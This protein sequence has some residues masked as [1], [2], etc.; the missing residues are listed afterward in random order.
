MVIANHHALAH[1]YHL[2]SA[3]FAIP[4][5]RCVV[6]D[7]QQQELGIGQAGVLA[8]DCEQSPL[9][10]FQGYAASARQPFVGKY[11]ITGDMVSLNADGGI[12]FIARNDDV[13]TTSGYRIGPFD[14]E[15]TLLECEAVFESAVIGKPDALRTEIIKAF[16]VLKAQYSASEALKQQLQDY[17]RSRLSY[18]AYPKEIEFVAELPKTPSGKIQRHLLKQRE[19]AQL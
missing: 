1:P 3:G 2:G 8:I 16:V 19:L 11:Y 18:H 4:G 9:F 17:V 7:P 5:H 13:I 15:S 6:L 14:V 10:W 12:N